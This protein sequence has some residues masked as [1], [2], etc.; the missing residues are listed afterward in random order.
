L[1][2]YK[3]PLKKSAHRVLDPLVRGLMA[4]GLKADH[5]TVIG[6][7]LSAVSG[8]AFYDGQFRLGATFLLIAGLCD[9]LDGQVA[10]MGGKVTRFGAFLDSTLDRLAESFVLLGLAAYYA[11]NL[12]GIYRKAAA[13]VGQVASG[14]VEPFLATIILNRQSGPVPETWVVLTVTSVLALTGSF[15]VSYT[16]ARAEGLGYECRVGWFERPERIVLLILA[17]FVQAFWAMSVAL[18]LLTVF[19][20]ATAVQRLLHVKRLAAEADAVAR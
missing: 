13:L 14:E 17:G 10:R 20:F 3:E 8:W 16:R 7:L 2:G 11:S 19:S 18:I 4:V 12:L 5:L 15:M 1:A 9:I 6:L